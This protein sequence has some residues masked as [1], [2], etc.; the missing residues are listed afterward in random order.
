MND[1]LHRTVVAY[2]GLE[3]FNQFQHVSAALS[4]GGT[5]WSLKG[6]QERNNVHVT[7]ELHQEHASFALSTL[8][9]QRVVFT[10]RRVAVETDQGTVVAE[11]ANPRATFAGHTRETPWDTLDRFYSSGSAM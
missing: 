9:N 10:P 8:P 3:R 7:V 6:G 2:G 4:I 11:R 1:L 5:L